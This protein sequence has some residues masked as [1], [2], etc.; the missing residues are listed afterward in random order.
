[1]LMK[2]TVL[3]VLICIAITRIKCFDN[4]EITHEMFK[5]YIERQKRAIANCFLS[6]K[7]DM[8][9]NLES[10]KRLIERLKIN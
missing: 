4:V 10:H 9:N 3:L 6:C 2:K 1:M 8:E 5:K 7:K